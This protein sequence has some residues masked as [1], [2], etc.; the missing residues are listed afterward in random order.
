MRNKRS[1][2]WRKDEL[3]SVDASIEMF[4][5]VYCTEKR[6]GMRW[7]STKLGA[8]FSYHKMFI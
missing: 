2:R 3:S 6:S 4:V 1:W 8:N 5:S 7:V